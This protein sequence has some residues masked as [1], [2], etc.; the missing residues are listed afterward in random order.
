MI[1]RAF[2]KLYL[3]C[4]PSLLTNAIPELPWDGRRLVIHAAKGAD[5]LD[6]GCHLPVSGSLKNIVYQAVLATQVGKLRDKIKITKPTHEGCT[7]ATC[8][9]RRYISDRYAPYERAFYRRTS[10]RRVTGVHLTGV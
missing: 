7:S 9:P 3:C 1:R 10:H 8:T 5:D 4:F 2:N 6:V